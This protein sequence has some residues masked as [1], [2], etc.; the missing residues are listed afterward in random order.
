MSEDPI[1]LLRE[2][3]GVL[4]P[5]G[6]AGQRGGG[7]GQRGGGALKGGVVADHGGG[8]AG[9]WGMIAGKGKSGG[10]M[11]DSACHLGAAWI[12]IM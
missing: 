10:G 7:A 6:G 8:G 3:E 2:I 5:G 11:K 4:D 12:I 1:H 9:H